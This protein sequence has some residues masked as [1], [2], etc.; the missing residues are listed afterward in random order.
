[1][2]EENQLDLSSFVGKITKAYI[3]TAPVVVEKIAK[4]GKPFKTYTMNVLVDGNRLELK[5][6]MRNQ[7]NN[8]V[9]AYGKDELQYI[10]KPIILE[11]V[12][13]NGFWTWIV[14]PFLK[15]TTEKVQ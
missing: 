9:T 15:T 1:M 3:E 5:G 13:E 11:R 10:G 8:I 6:L 2:L 14:N 7:L 12:K 4:N